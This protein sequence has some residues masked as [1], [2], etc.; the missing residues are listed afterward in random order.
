VKVFVNPT[1]PLPGGDRIV[2][3]RMWDMEAS[4]EEPRTLHDFA[5]WRT[6]LTSV[7]EL[8]AYRDVTRNLFVAPGDARPVPVAEISA[9]A[10]RIA[11]GTPLMG[12]VLV[13]ADEQAGA[14]PVVVL[15]YDVWRTRFASRPDIVGRTVQLGDAFA[16]VVGVMP[17]GFAFPVSHDLWTP[18]RAELLEQAPREGPDIN[19]FGRLAPGR[20]LD[21]AQAELATL[22][23]R[24]SA[25][26]PNTHRHLQPRVLPYTSNFPEPSMADK[27]LMLAIP[28]FAVML[29]VLV[30]SNVALLLFARAATRENELIVRSA[31]GA[32]RGRIIAQLFTEA[33]VLGGLA[34][35]IG[36]TAAHAAL[37]QWG[38]P[39]LEVNYGRMPFWYDLHL[40]PA[41]VF[42]SI[43]LTVLC[44]AIAGVGPGLKVTQGLGTRLRQSTA[45]GG[46]RFGGIWTAVIVTQIAFTVAFPAI[47]YLMN[48]EAQRIRSVDVGFPAREY[49]A[50]RIEAESAPLSGA[51][52]A[53]ARAAQ[54]ARFGTT[55]EALRQRVA[56]EPGVS[57]V[58]FVDHLP[59]LYHP[60]LRIELD[61]P[62]V[63][64]GQTG[65]STTV[66]KYP[67]EVNVAEVDPSYFAVLDAPILAGRGFDA[68]DVAPDARAVIVDRG[69]VDQVLAGRNA[70][71][72]RVR[73]AAETAPDGSLLEEANPWYEIVGV[74]KEL[75]TGGVTQRGRASGFYLPVAPERAEPLQ[76]LVRVQGDPLAMSPRVRAIA[77]TVDPAMRL[78]EFARLDQVADGM[79]WFV[80]V[81]LRVTV[82]LTGVALLLSLSGIYAVLSFTVARRTREIG[83]RVALGAS[84]R[85]VVTEI[86]RRPLGQVAVGVLVGGALIMLGARLLEGSEFTYNVALS[87]EQVVVILAYAV[88][89]LGVCMLACVVP[90][91][92]ALRVEPTEALR[93]D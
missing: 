30:C 15:G 87:L 89:M 56:A 90:T 65:A 85:R 73:F 79:L 34:A 26:Q 36:L 81:W 42:Y 16:T 11:S 37:Q 38:M 62:S 57:G 52:S 46:L 78:T 59:R 35:A 67:G 33:L 7:T 91:R 88:L 44:A 47:T 45:G 86:F 18:L 12:R 60:Q 27:A 68:G 2:Q 76:M 53:T 41:T 64:A 77:A 5:A 48:W 19:V 13:A 21:E 50:V 39:Y 24:A 55:L 80:G 22:G 40:S 6:A 3:L 49:L 14:P 83:V 82:L 58:T 51:D 84:R 23:R 70:V 32:T 8:G 66:V 54:R 31:L 63:A 25:E 71:G 29:L 4:H 43:G 9:S 93:V 74:V 17:E 69:F 61:D 75:G 92:R 20:T 28:V 1:L 72:R 10:F